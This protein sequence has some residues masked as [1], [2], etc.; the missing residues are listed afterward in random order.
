MRKILIIVFLVCLAIFLVISIQFF[1][2]RTAGRGAL[3]VTSAPKSAVY[4]DGKLIG[5]TPLCKC[6]AQDMIQ[7]GDYAIRLVPIDTLNSQLLPFEKKISIQKSIL[8]VVDRT[9][10]GGAGSEG[11]IITLH[12]LQDARSVELLI[13]SFPDQADVFLDNSPSGMTP[14]LLKNVTSSDHEV[15]LVKSGYKDKAVRIKTTPGYQLESL[16]FL[17][18]NPETDIKPTASPSANPTPQKQK[19]LILQTPTGFLRV[20]SAST[21]SASEIARVNPGESYEL[22]DEKEGWFQIKLEN[23]T[24]GWISASYARKQ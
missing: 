5:Q 4:L 13:L 11:S 2:L 24:S 6:Q 12:S 20:R 14:L 17:G 18:I 19:V 16:I 15:K 10:G 8:T 21:I 7:S 22:L 3:Q 9:F 1:I 23:G